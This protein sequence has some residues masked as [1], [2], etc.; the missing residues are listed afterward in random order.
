MLAHRRVKGIL[1]LKSLTGNNRSITASQMLWDAAN[2]NWTIVTSNHMLPKSESL[3][4]VFYMVYPETRKAQCFNIIY[5]GNTNLLHYLNAKLGFLRGCCPVTC[6]DCHLHNSRCACSKYSQ[7]GLWNININSGKEIGK[8]ADPRLGIWSLL[9]AA[10]TPLG[11][12]CMKSQGFS[13]ESGVYGLEK[14]HWRGYVL[15]SR[16]GKASVYTGWRPSK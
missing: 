12:N 14:R 7:L 1:C 10:Y 2:S 8:P 4:D 3:S 5:T 13:R 16:C 9:P 15:L 6:N 11:P